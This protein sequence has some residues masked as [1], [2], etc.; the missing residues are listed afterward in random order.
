MI[1]RM[2]PIVLLLCAVVMLT[3]HAAT[4]T[5]DPAA[6]TVHEWGTF[7]SIAGEDGNAVDWYLQQG[8]SD[9]PC[10]VDRLPFRT[11]GWA[12]GTVR[13]E[14]P[15]LYFYADTEMAVNVR[16]RFRQG[17]L[18]EWFPKATVTPAEFTMTTAF[19]RPDFEGAISW[20]NV[21][22]LPRA[23]QV[24]PTDNRP[25][26]YYPARETDASPVQVGSHKEKFLFYRG[27]ARFAPPISATVASDGTIVVKHPEGKP[28]GDII[29]FENRAG[30]TGYRIQRAAGAR[31]TLARPSL[32][33]GSA[34][35]YQELEGMLVANGL[36]PREARAMIET[37][38]DSWSE[39]GTRVFYVVS[40]KAVDS[41]LPLEIDPV[42]TAVARVFIGRLEIVTSEMLH[43]VEAAIGT[44]DRVTLRRYG[45]FF[46]PIVRRL[47]AAA[48]EVDR[49]T[50][51]Q[52]L[53]AVYASW[54]VAPAS[55]H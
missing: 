30:R 51:D 4:R 5:N 31:A 9:L 40:R 27:V 54:H 7:T 25:S 21:K 55:C 43:D 29:L 17:I 36:Y 53:R 18:T 12:P 45:R 11:K 46:D 37:W 6:L 13:M 33:N 8:P 34:P 41:I 1:R 23:D 44:N 16:V 15:V 42:P 10:F 24:F 26:H 22:V 47:R 39:E 19:G 14:T 32:H 20:N 50:L 38:R 3:A 52:N 28:L 35:P 49:R 48:T 2:A